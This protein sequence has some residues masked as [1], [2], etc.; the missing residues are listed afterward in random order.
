MLTQ[1]IDVLG[2]ANNHRV[3]ALRI[4]R[5][6]QHGT[7]SRSMVPLDDFSLKMANAVIVTKERYIVVLGQ[8]WGDLERRG[9]LDEK[10][11]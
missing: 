4:K 2:N 11:Q 10:E 1:R 5:C 6:A 8:F 9:D 3:V 7:S